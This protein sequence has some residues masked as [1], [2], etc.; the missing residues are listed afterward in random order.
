MRIGL[1]GDLHG[2]PDLAEEWIRRAEPDFCLQAGDYWCYDHPWSVPVYWMF[3]N[4]ERG[5]YIKQIISGRFT[6]PT[7][8]HWLQGGV[9]EIHSIT[10]M[11]LPGWPKP[12]SDPGPAGYPQ[13]VYDLCM[14]Q[15]DQPVDILISHG[16]GFPFADW[17]YDRSQIK[18]VLRNFE[19]HD[20]TTLIKKVRP[21]Y[22]V[23]VH[24]HRYAIEE[25]EGISC[26]RL[27]C[28]SQKHTNGPFAT[29]IEI[30]Q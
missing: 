25:H 6:F 17:M 7:N 4:H 30:D 5:D 8:S 9:E 16:C 19:E 18:P 20:I 3:G 10:V 2:E 1:L 11:A 13:P 15:A 24:N 28:T 21:T 12:G 26:I 22:A 14:E 27:G 29:L 23:S